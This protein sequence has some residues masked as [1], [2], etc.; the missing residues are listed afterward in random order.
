[1]GHPLTVE[2]AARLTGESPLTVPRPVVDVGEDQDLRRNVLKK[3]FPEQ[4]AISGV[5]YPRSDAVTRG[6]LEQTAI[7]RI[8]R[9]VGV[10]VPLVF[11]TKRAHGR[12]VEGGSLAQCRRWI[13]KAGQ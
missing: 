1:M 3:L 8:D 4:T 12:R 2:Q 10:I 13:V 11:Q 6:R 9:F 7:W 5:R